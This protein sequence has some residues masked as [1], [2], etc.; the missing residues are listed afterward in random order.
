M[1]II[2][3]SAVYSTPQ[4]TPYSSRA[5]RRPNPRS[6][7]RGF[8]DFM[9][10]ARR[11]QGLGLLKS[12]SPTLGNHS[13]WAGD[14]EQGVSIVPSVFARAA[15]SKQTHEC[16]ERLLRSARNDTGKTR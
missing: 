8:G 10:V 15:G 12:Y 11:R 14:V 6:S 9:R 4:A 7:A 2:R 13:K 5:F 16:K 3:K 1:P